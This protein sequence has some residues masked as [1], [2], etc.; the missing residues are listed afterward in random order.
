MSSRTVMLTQMK[1]RALW[2]LMR[3]MC[4]VSRTQMRWASFLSAVRSLLHGWSTFRVACC[5]KL[6]SAFL[7]HC[8][9]ETMGSL[10]MP[11][12]LGQV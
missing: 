2:P 11:L 10:P 7:D 9:P 5:G 6:N 1:T 4:Q 3:T 8:D 12:E